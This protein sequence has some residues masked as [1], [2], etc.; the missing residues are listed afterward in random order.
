MHNIG[1]KIFGDTNISYITLYFKMKAIYV[2][3]SA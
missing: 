1:R 2:R 3:C